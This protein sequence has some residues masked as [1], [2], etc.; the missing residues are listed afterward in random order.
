MSVQEVGQDMEQKGHGA[1]GG[2]DFL[3]TP[4]PV[5]TA[6]AKLVLLPPLGVARR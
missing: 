5:G 6:V 2:G 1:G 3:H 4:V